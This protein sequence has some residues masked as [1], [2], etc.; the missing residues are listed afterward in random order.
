MQPWGENEVQTRI[1]QPTSKCVEES[2]VNYN[3]EGKE[4]EGGHGSLFLS[5]LAS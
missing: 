4:V 3:R 5:K 2:Y 1:T